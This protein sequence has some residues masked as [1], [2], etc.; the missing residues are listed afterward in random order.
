MRSKDLLTLAL[1]GV[2]GWIA[3]EHFG[4]GKTWGQS[5]ATLPG[6]SSLASSMGLTGVDG[7]GCASCGTGIT[8]IAPTNFFGGYVPGG[9]GIPSKAER[10]Y[11]ARF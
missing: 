7:L 9:A 8:G 4:V 10:L 6:G 1:V 3:Y 2:V 11:A 5:L